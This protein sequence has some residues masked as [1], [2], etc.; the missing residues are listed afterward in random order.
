M[1]HARDFSRLRG[2]LVG[3]SDRVLDA[4]LRLYRQ[5]VDQLNALEA[6]YPMMDWARPAGGGE[7]DRDDRRLL[8]VPVKGLD[9]APVGP[10]DDAIQLL[11]AEAR[12]RGLDVGALAMTFGD[13]DFWTTDRG[14]TINVPWFLA[15]PTLWRLASRR[16]ETAYT[17]EQVR[18][19]LRHE[20]GH[21]VFFA[22][23]LGASRPWREQFG[24]PSAA[25]TDVYVADPRARTH[26]EYLTGVPRHYAQKHPEEA[27]AE[28]FAR[29]LDGAGGWREEYAAWPQALAK[30]EYVDRLVPALG[31]PAN[32][33][34]GR[35]VPYR[36]LRGTV[37]E[38]LGL[39]T[40]P[41]V[42]AGLGLTQHG[43]LL[44]R[45][46]HLYDAVVLHESYFDALGEGTAPPPQ[47]LAA[48][49][50]AW[51]SW[52][53][54]LLDLRAIAANTHGW[55]LTVW[56]PR[57]QR[58][59]N[60][61]VEGHSVGVLAGCP[62]LLAIDVHEHSYA[63][64]FLDRKDVYLGA[65][66]RNV[67]WR[68]VAARLLHADPRGI[69]AF[70][71]TQE[72]EDSDPDR[73][74]L[75]LLRV[76]DAVPDDDRRMAGREGLVRMD[77]E[78]THTKTGTKFM[79]PYWVSP[80]KAKTAAVAAGGPRVAE[81][82]K[83]VQFKPMPKREWTGTT[84]E[85]FSR[86]QAEM[87]NAAQRAVGEIALA[88]QLASSHYIERD[89]VQYPTRGVTSLTT[90]DNLTLGGRRTSGV[91]YPDGRMVLDS[92]VADELRSALIDGEAKTPAQKFAVH[93]FL[94]EAMHGASRPDALYEG[95][96][97][98][99]G[100]RRPH[101]AMQEAITDVLAHHYKRQFAQET[102]GL[103]WEQPELPLYTLPNAT[104]GTSSSDVSSSYHPFVERFGKLVVLGAGLDLEKGHSSADV[105]NEAARLAII[106]KQQPASRY[107]MLSHW[108]LRKAPGWSELPARWRRTVAMDDAAEAFMVGEINYDELK[109]RREAA[110]APTFGPATT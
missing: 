31:K 76:L 5:Y 53:S 65:F 24:D 27:W 89:A 8:G 88:G 70:T 68:V 63:G 35:P 75:A 96:P 72:F 108:L 30:L 83:V 99:P 22:Y 106:L 60:A 90:E 54:Y 46:P 110:L 2:T 103:K 105:Q 47:L 4:H 19:C 77:K 85:A 45:E 48:A 61:L 51:G 100:H 38:R 74:T 79:R 25:Y 13:E 102:L 42:G 28:A 49:C 67:D 97:D 80:A 84:R 55:A 94:H 107:Q 95:L 50:A 40:D 3:I 62:V 18:R 32:R 11:H 101:A 93:V 7:P 64:D 109:A 17:P 33:Y 71:V 41:V 14:C 23:E 36:Q 15:N 37:A 98:E 81:A 87:M 73:V 59:R 78:I 26:V 82:E 56:D 34:P 86:N 10:L 66:F 12:G 20:L 92:D 69:G 39:P 29:W 6:L 1:L 52:E 91:H 57:A 21:V 16:P 104:T 43:E 44:R 9:L 58:M